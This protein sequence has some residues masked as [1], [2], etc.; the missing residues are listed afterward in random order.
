M[1]IDG[2]AIADGILESLRPKVSALKQ[3]GV[4]PTLAVIQIGDDPGSTAYI[5]QKQKSAEQIGAKLIL[6]H[7]SSTVSYQQLQKIIEE[8]NNNPSIHGIIVQRPLPEGL[9]TEGILPSKDVDGFLPDSPYDVPVAMA[10]QK[11]LDEVF[12]TSSV[13]SHKS[14]V[15]LGRGETAGK[16]IAEAL[17][18]RG[19]NVII[20][21][22]RTSNP[23][24]AIRVADIVISCVGKPNIVRRDNIKRGAILISVG[25]S[26][27][28]EGKLRG[29]YEEDEVKDVAFFFTPTPGG[30]G[31]ANV[32]YLMAN[33]VK[34]AL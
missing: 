18:K 26:R 33:L 16:P 12:P 34:A 25:L 3:N 31:P 9:R 17:I 19:C 2:N 11:I 15:V 23:D 5:R 8:Y 21:H 27:D 28:N 7:Q 6:S 4:T 30:V 22:S 1:R 14:V 20:V 24:D 32:A 29:D 13:F 10:V